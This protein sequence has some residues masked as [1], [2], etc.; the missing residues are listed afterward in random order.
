MENWRKFINEA[1]L[2]DPT[3]AAIASSQDTQDAVKRSQAAN[4]AMLGDVPEELFPII[5]KVA[6]T[7]ANIAAM[8]ADPSGQ[9]AGYDPDTKKLTTSKEILD[10]EIL[11][12]QQ[13][14]TLTSAAS[15][16]VAGLSMLPILGGVA[17]LGRLR[18][19]KRARAQFKPFDV[20][21]PMLIRRL[22]Q[23]GADGANMLMHGK[24]ILLQLKLKYK[25]NP[26]PQ[27][28]GAIQMLAV[29]LNQ[30]KRGVKDLHK[31][32]ET[33][34]Q[35]KI[36]G[37]TIS[38]LTKKGRLATAGTRFRGKVYKG[39]SVGRLSDLRAQI[40]LPSAFKP[41]GKVGDF[42]QEAFNLA[43]RK[44]GQ[45]VRL[46]VPEGTTVPSTHGAGAS[47]G[48][49]FTKSLDNAKDFSSGAL[50]GT[51]S[52][53]IEVMLVASGKKV[54]NIDAGVHFSKTGTS[55][56]SKGASVTAKSA[57]DVVMLGDNIPI[58]QIWIKVNL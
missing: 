53:R 54:K 40:N 2:T 26:D 31:H 41:G 56:T 12:F 48:E 30:V 35:S 18:V 47:R 8:A 24:K 9:F 3:I 11:S 29:A 42:A 28:A 17:K 20:D 1:T 43:Q 27:T 10:Q 15:V 19:I 37:S 16:A 6:I 7:A 14:P 50:P 52:G 21:D 33:F 58:D 46:R 39:K 32:S 38:S 34:G 4:R 5:K 45:W 51:K 49:V 36:K 55:T 25:K 44:R 22:Y 57:E 13:K 23:P